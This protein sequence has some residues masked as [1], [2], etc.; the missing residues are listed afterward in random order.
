MSTKDAASRYKGNYDDGHNR[1]DTD[2]EDYRDHQDKLLRKG[3]D[4][5]V[6]GRKGDKS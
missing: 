3:N 6:L 4:E 1:D 5:G 2:D